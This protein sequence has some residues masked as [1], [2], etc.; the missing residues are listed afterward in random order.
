MQ[1]REHPESVQ[2]FVTPLSPMLH[3]SASRAIDGFR[4]RVICPQR[5][6]SP[7]VLSYPYN[8]IVQRTEEN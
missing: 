7:F 8:Q 1:H 4:F 6:N 2:K 5:Q 3:F